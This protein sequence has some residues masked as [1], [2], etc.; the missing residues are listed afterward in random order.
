MAETLRYKAKFAPLR[1]LLLDLACERT[2]ESVVARVVG[3]L[4]RGRQVALCR[5]WLLPHGDPPDGASTLHLAASAGAS[6]VDQT[7]PWTDLNGRFGGIPIG[8]GKIGRIAQSGEALEVPD[9]DPV[10]DWIDDPSWTQ[11]EGIRGFGGRPLVYDGRTLGVLAVFTRVR[12]EED[13][14]VWLRMIADHTAAALVNARAYEELDRL[15]GQLNN[16][17]ATTVDG[18]GPTSSILTEAQMVDLDQRN[19]R[20]ALDATS[21][22]IYG[23]GGAAEFLGLRPTTLASRIKKY[24]LK[25]ST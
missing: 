14:L 17:P 15:R 24:G 22:K 13:W 25:R 2:K 23:I 20:A 7:S 4:T 18:P 19:L 10:D 11:R 16:T 9:V 5:I 3:C 6:I 1:E 12:L 8:V 21:W